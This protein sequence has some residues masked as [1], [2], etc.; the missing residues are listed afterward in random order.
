VPQ[1]FVEMYRKDLQQLEKQKDF[2]HSYAKKHGSQGFSNMPPAN[3][4][5]AALDYMSKNKLIGSDYL[6]QLRQSVEA[7]KS[8][9]ELNTI[10]N[11][12]WRMTGAGIVKDQ[13]DTMMHTTARSNTLTAARP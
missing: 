5:E 7:A 8:D 3:R 9:Y 13:W 4:A 12:L 6:T 2:Q 11:A 10:A 1:Q